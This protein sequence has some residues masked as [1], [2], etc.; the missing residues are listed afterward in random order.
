VP[1]DEIAA[2]TGLTAEQLA[3]VIRDIE[4]KRRTTSY[5]H[6]RPV[7]VDEVTEID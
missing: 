4:Q 2:A 3:R 6:D 5:L 7:L 1:A